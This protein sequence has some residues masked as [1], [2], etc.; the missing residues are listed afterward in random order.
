MAEALPVVNGLC[1]KYRIKFAYENHPEKTPQEI[2][3][4]AGNGQYEHVGVALDTGW[5]GTHA[6][7]ALEAVKAVRD[8]LF[9][10]HL[11]DVQA[12][13]RH[14]TCAL[15]EGV[16]PVEKVVRYLVESDWH[17]TLCIEHE[18]FDRDPMPA[19]K[20]S[21]ERVKQWLTK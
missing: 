17:G 8:R 5:C 9:I 10:I 3:D 13:G 2:L 14:D 7:D 18:P 19:V 12:H 20:R 11:K 4:R 21:V 1:E 6:M 15:G 16:V